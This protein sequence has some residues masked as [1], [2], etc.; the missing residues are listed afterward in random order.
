[1]D[2][3]SFNLKVQG[4]LSRRWIELQKRVQNAVTLGKHQQTVRIIAT[5][6][7][8]MADPVME[9]CEAGI[10]NFSED[11]LPEGITKKP[12][13]QHRFPLT[14][15]HFTGVIQPNKLHL[16]VEFFDWVHLFDR[17]TLLKPLSEAC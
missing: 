14:I 8:L 1:M 4:A 10:A 17:A 15:W 5:S 7:G 3:P 16:V 12:V 11:Y 9:A 13:I 2:L 6:R